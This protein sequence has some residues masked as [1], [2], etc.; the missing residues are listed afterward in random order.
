MFATDNTAVLRT[1]CASLVVMSWIDV[2]KHKVM[3]RKTIPYL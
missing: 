2:A 3:Y 1:V